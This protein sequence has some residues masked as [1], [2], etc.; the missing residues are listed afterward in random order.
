[1]AGILG[2]LWSFDADF[3]TWNQKRLQLVRE[4]T[5]DIQLRE[6]TDFPEG[7]KTGDMNSD[8]EIGGRP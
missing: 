7:R 3:N 5:R 1:L 4:I 6:V 8:F 2:N